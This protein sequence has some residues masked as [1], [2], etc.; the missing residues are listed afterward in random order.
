[1]SSLFAFHSHA[2]SRYLANRVYNVQNLR[3]RSHLC[4][5][6][7]PCNLQKYSNQ[8]LQIRTRETMSARARIGFFLSRALSVSP[9]I[10]SPIRNNR[11]PG[12]F[13]PLSLSP[14]PSHSRSL[15]RSLGNLIPQFSPAVRPGI[16]SIS[17]F[18]SFS[19]LRLFPRQSFS[20]SRARA[21]SKLAASFYCIRDIAVIA[22]I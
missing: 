22:F 15:S 3:D 8:T 13:T 19:F 11:T 2:R 10:L 14:S 5:S 21:H 16:T 1:M 4:F 6:S 9:F 20:L 18:P 7:P 12:D 17:H